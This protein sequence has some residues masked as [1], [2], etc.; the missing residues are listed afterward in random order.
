[1]MFQKAQKTS[2]DNVIQKISKGASILQPYSDDN[3]KELPEINNEIVK[4]SL[5]NLRLS[6][7]TSTPQCE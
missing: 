5:Q 7:D 1:M 2:I 3:Q 6:Y 4:Q